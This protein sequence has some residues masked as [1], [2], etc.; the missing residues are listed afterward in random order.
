MGKSRSNPSGTANPANYVAKE[1]PPVLKADKVKGMA[2]NTLQPFFADD[3]IGLNADASLSG[4]DELRFKGK[5][6]AFLQ[7][8]GVAGSNDGHFVE[9]QSKAMTYKTDFPFAIPHEMLLKPRAPGL[10]EGM[11]K[12]PG[13]FGTFPGKGRRFFDNFPGDFMGPFKFFADRAD[14]E[15]P[16]L[17]GDVAV[18]ACAIIKDDRLIA[19]NDLEG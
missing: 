13:A 18:I 8:L 11:F 12:N 5:D 16:C 6:H 19:L 4:K 9:L 3:E 2:G 14:H 7:D 1:V 15:G 10:A 17:V